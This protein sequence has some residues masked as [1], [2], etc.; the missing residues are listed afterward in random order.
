MNLKWIIHAT[1]EIAA[2]VKYKN[3]KP[4]SKRLKKLWITNSLSNQKLFHLKSRS[5]NSQ[6]YIFLLSRIATIRHTHKKINYKNKLND[7]TKNECVECGMCG[8]IIFK[9][10]ALHTHWHVFAKLRRSAHL[11]LLYLIRQ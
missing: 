3:L 7:I 1:E 10:L 5:V 2:L 11:K 8:K 9:C 4:L 6:H